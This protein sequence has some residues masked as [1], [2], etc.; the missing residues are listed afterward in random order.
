MQSLLLALNAICPR[1]PMVRPELAGKMAILQWTAQRCRIIP[2]HVSGVGLRLLA[3]IP[4][5]M[6]GHVE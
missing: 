1:Q 4:S 5:G 3:G 2:V 6:E